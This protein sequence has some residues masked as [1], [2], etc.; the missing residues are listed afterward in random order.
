MGYIMQDFVSIKQIVED[1][2]NVKMLTINALAEQIDIKV[3]FC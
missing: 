1:A 3:F 2:G